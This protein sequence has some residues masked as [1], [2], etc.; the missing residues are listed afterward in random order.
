MQMITLNSCGIRETLILIN[1]EGNE[2]TRHQ[3]PDQRFVLSCAVCTIYGIEIIKMKIKDF[4]GFN[5]GKRI[6]EL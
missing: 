6:G 3:F 1:Y 4:Y 5:F 2:S